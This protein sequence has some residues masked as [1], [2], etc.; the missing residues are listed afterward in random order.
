MAGDASVRSTIR[1]KHP[2]GT[3]SV[4]AVEREK[5]GTL[6]CPCYLLG[7]ITYEQNKTISGRRSI[8]LCSSCFLYDDEKTTSLE[9][10][11]RFAHFEN[12]FQSDSGGC[13]ES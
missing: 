9:M 1:P 5:R 12:V 2:K 7:A 13:I 6:T 8:L 3:T 10:R 11:H 4:S